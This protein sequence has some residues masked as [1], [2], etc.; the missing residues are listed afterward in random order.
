M[1]HFCKRRGLCLVALLLVG[2]MLAP[3]SLAATGD[4]YTGTE[5]PPPNRAPYLPKHDSTVLQRVPSRNNPAIVKMRALRAQLDA[6]PHDVQLADKLARAYVS[7][8]REIGD[9]HYSGYAT[10]VIAPWMKLKEPPPPVLVTQAVILQFLHK[11]DPARKLLQA[12]IKRAPN[13]AQAWLTLSSVDMIQGR[14]DEANID[15]VRSAQSGGQLLGIMCSGALRSFTGHAEQAQKMLMLISAT[16]PKIPKPVESY[17]QGLL[18]ETAG[19]LGQ[20]EQAEMHFKKA[21]SFTP[22]DNFTLVNYA[23]LLLYLHRPKEVLRLLNDDQQSDTAFLRIALAHQQLKSPDLARYT[24][25]MAARF[26]ALTLRGSHLFGRE[27]SRFALHLLHDPQLALQLAERNWKVQRAP[28]DQRVFLEAA[29]AAN[30]P[31]A[32]R[33]VL[34]QLDQTHLQDPIIQLL[35]AKVRAA[36][37]AEKKS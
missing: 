28:W 22:H 10:A 7:F 2:A 26:E 29:L 19:R 11:F 4:A 31:A 37:A 20:W 8:G 15:C 1:I 14:Y 21:L 24:W 33:P 6:K 13:N 35:A 27:H 32:A 17:I 16:A 9:A 30:K 34:A 23:D 12:A 25:I 36:I 5:P 3:A 18:A